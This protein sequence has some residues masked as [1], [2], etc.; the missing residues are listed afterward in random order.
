LL[1]ASLLIIILSP[2]MLVLAVLV[3]RSSPGPIL[4]RQE[5]VGAQG[6]RFQFLKF[7]S[8]RADADPTLHQQYVAAFIRG[9]AEK[10]AEGEGDATLY[11]LSDDPRITPTGRWLRR[12]SLDELPQLFNVIH[13][14]MSLVGPRPPIPYELEHYQKEQFRRLAVKP[15]ITGLWQVSG[16]SR[17]TFD[18]MVDLDL[19]YIQDASFLTDLRILFKTI[20]VVFFDQSA[21]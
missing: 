6:R 3:W 4:F 11:K 10:A 13:G 17:T 2:L 14:E 18:E 20:P 21:R 9:Q 12:T 8:M 19:D 15:G 16:R 5:R 7:R 1:V